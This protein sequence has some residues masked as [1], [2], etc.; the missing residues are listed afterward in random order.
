MTNHGNSGLNA[1]YDSRLQ[2][3]LYHMFWGLPDEECREQGGPRPRFYGVGFLDLEH[4]GNSVNEYPS[5]TGSS[6]GQLGSH[7]HV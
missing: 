2:D 4:D 5:N 7:S 1:V 6:E 3:E